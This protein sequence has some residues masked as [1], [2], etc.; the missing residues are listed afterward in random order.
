MGDCWGPGETSRPR[1]SVGSVGVRFG[2]SYV[3]AEMQ[4]LPSSDHP[5]WLNS[6]PTVILICAD[7]GAMV[8]DEETHTEFHAGRLSGGHV[9]ARE[10][11]DKFTDRF[12]GAVAGT[13]DV[14][15]LVAALGRVS[16][17]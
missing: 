5:A 2:G 16:R 6:H 4:E 9:A 7:C 12:F 17:A 11:V 8:L 3:R 15:V 10:L 1:D 13:A 14:D